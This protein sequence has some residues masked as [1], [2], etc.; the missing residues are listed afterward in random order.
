ML[1]VA[2]RR[3]YI[4]LVDWLAGGSQVVGTL[5]MNSNVQS[6]WWRTLHGS[7]EAEL[8]SL[9]DDAHVYSWDVGSR[10]CLRKWKDDGGFGTVLL[11]GSPAGDY[12]AIGCA[13]NLTQ[14]AW[15]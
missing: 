12:T 8:M 14:T 9:G 1:A 3:G 11:G 13:T 2:G 6:L 15:N 10:R 4:H 7:G 5:K